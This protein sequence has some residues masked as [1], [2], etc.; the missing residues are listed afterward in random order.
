LLGA[1]SAEALAECLLA[2]LAD[3]QM[4]RRVMSARLDVSARYNWGRTAE[5]MLDAIGETVHS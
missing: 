4:H 1:G 3:E 2:T 5:I